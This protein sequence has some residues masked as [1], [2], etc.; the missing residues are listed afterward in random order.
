MWE[1][2]ELRK[3]AVLRKADPKKGQSQ[4]GMSDA[5]VI[6]DIAERAAGG[7]DVMI[8][9]APEI[10]AKWVIDDWYHGDFCPEFMKEPHYRWVLR[11]YSFKIADEIVKWISRWE[12]VIVDHEV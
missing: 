9:G 4:R 12:K 7:Y 8:D 11:E 5:F 1:P 2:M 3:V 10:Y 6:S